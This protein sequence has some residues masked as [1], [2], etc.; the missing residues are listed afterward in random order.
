MVS[1]VGR[2]NKSSVQPLQYKVLE[3]LFD[4]TI[5][6]QVLVFS[7]V[8]SRSRYPQLVTAILGTAKKEA[9]DT[10]YTAKVRFD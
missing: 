9:S 4:Q 10:D 3:V 2:S 8:E 6:E 7:E 1:G 5:Q